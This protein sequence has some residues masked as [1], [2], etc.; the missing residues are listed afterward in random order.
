MEVALYFSL[1]SLRALTSFSQTAACCLIGEAR[2]KDLAVMASIN[3]QQTVYGGVAEKGRYS[4]Y[5]SEDTC[6]CHYKSETLEGIQKVQQGL[7]G[8]GYLLLPEII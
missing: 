2:E 4:G 6:S 8:Q 1:M 3:S 5:S 7:S